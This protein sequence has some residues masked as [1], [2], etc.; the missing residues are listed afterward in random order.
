MSFARA[1]RSVLLLTVLLPL[2]CSDSKKQS[3]D[4][5][6]ARLPLGERIDKADGAGCH[7]VAGGGDG[8]AGLRFPPRPTD[9]VS[10]PY[11]RGNS[12][13]AIRRSFVGACHLS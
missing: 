11:N 12:D 13:E 10:G 8:P 9:F 4:N 2:G 5:S 3:P 6:G 1:S 7:G